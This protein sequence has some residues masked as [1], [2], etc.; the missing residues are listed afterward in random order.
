MKTSPKTYHYGIEIVP[1]YRSRSGTGRICRTVQGYEYASFH[2]VSWTRSIKDAKEEIDS[3]R[4]RLDRNISCLR[5]DALEWAKSRWSEYVEAIEVE[6]ARRTLQRGR[7]IEYE[8]TGDQ[9]RIFRLTVSLARVWREATGHRD[10]VQ[11]TSIS[12]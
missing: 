12:S 1:T 5:E 11:E 2:G 3:L 8:I 9:A 7:E 4:W 6:L 10:T